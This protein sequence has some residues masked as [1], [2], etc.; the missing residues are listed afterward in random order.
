ME[1]AE[2]FGGKF[3]IVLDLNDADHPSRPR[4]SL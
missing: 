4:P 3:L 1:I 2:R